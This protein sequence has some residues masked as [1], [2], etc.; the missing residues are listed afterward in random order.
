MRVARGSGRN[1]VLPGVDGPTA[2]GQLQ[3]DGGSGGLPSL[4]V[5]TL[6]WPMAQSVPG[7][8]ALIR[9]VADPGVRPAR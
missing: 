8:S 1:C 4:P 2:A 6:T 5:T 3:R 9:V 7:I